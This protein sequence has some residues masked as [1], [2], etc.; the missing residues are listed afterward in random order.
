MGWDDLF[1]EGSYMMMLSVIEQIYKEKREIK[2]IKIL[3]LTFEEF[4]YYI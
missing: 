3:E 1:N 2:V 4:F